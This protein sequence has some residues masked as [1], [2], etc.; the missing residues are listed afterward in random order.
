VQTGGRERTWNSVEIAQ[1]PNREAHWKEPLPNESGCF[2]L[3]LPTWSLT[4]LSMCAF[5]EG[6]PPSSHVPSSSLS[7]FIHFVFLAN[8]TLHARP[9]SATPNPFLDP[10]HWIMRYLGQNLPHLLPL[11]SL[12]LTENTG[13]KEKPL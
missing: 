10:H 11:T 1:L 9:V 13:E 6:W 3:H 5:N 2:V 7:N 12:K 4:P 8:W